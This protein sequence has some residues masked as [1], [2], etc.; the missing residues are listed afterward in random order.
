MK[1]ELIL[2]PP[3]TGKTTTLLN[4]VESKLAEGIAP[5]EIAFVSFTRKAA[6][7]A[8]DRAL[9]KFTHLYKKSFIHFRTLHSTAYRQL[10]IGRGDLL[11]TEDLKNVGRLSGLAFSGYI[12]QMEGMSGAASADP[13]DLALFLIGVAR[14]KMI[15]PHKF[16]DTLPADVRY[17]I[18]SLK[19]HHFLRT[20]EKFKEE[21][22]QLDF[23]DLL[24]QAIHCGPLPRIKVAIVDEAQDLT[25][26]QWAYVES[27]FKNVNELY[28]AGDDDQ[29]IYRWSGA[30][31]DTFLNLQGQ[32]T[33]LERSWRLPREIW[34]YANKF[35]KRISKRYEK[36]WHPNDEPGQVKFHTK[37]HYVPIKEGGEWLLLVRNTYQM[38]EI[39]AM[40]QD[41][42]VP[43]AVRGESQ[44]R[45]SHM[46]SIMNWERLRK[47]EILSRSEAQNIYDHLLP[48]QVEGSKDLQ[49]AMQDTFSM[50][51]LSM[52][53]GLLVYSDVDWWDALKK[54][55]KESSGYYRRI[56][57]NGEK[58]S[59]TPRVN[60]STVH[61][62]KGGEA[63]NVMLLNAM[64]ART[65]RGY[66]TDPDDEHRVFY[67]G[68]TR[69]KK[70]LHLVRT[71]G[72]ND[73]P[74]PTNNSR[75][76]W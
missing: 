71:A 18:T 59:G 9:E 41:W 2:G 65:R 4:I 5:E 34:A 37:A 75:L 29:A 32:R 30:D 72:K 19:Y 51:D 20:L 35:T 73:Y 62:V 47:G 57:R 69:A 10:Q 17:E 46:R 42:G 6:N 45:S 7:E 36:D 14:A 48:E 67:V 68:A 21:T 22:G 13:G 54:I 27:L 39:K 74:L 15:D 64:S 63:D 49:F 53:H 66:E 38:R 31:I 25:K 40:L 1:R 55:P 3:G 24:E 28:V 23:H 12:N 8:R 26:V 76:T 43:Y 16:Y 44:I 56:R 60:L 52:N 11:G 50:S 33:V 70:A 61:G 58:L